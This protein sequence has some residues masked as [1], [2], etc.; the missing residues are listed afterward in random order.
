MMNCAVLDR[1]GSSPGIKVGTV[2]ENGLLQSDAAKLV[3]GASQLLEVG[4]PLRIY[5]SGR[6]RKGKKKDATGTCK[7]LL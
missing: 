5:M 3:T 1:E 7:R 6:V 4:I 2:A